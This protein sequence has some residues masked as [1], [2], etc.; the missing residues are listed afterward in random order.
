MIVRQTAAHVRV[1]DDD[2]LVKVRPPMPATTLAPLVKLVAC[3]ACGGTG[4]NWM[5]RHNDSLRMIETGRECLVCEGNGEFE[6]PILCE[7]C[8]EPAIVVQAMVYLCEDCA[9]RRRAGEPLLRH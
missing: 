8:D 1:S 3:D 9:G 6:L 5:S 7:D 4:G 2:A